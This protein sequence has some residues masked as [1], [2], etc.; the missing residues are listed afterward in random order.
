MRLAGSPVRTG[1]WKA[2]DFQNSA[3]ENTCFE[4]DVKIG[5]VIALTGDCFLGV[6]NL[7]KEDN[8]NYNDAKL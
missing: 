4:K 6:F 8:G 1:F 5:T 3:D 2:C 7:S